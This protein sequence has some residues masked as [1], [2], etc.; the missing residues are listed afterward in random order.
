MSTVSDSVNMRLKNPSKENNRNLLSNTFENEENYIDNIIKVL[1]DNLISKKEILYLE[2]LGEF[3][4]G[5]LND[6]LFIDMKVAL[7]HLYNAVCLFTQNSEKLTGSVSKFIEDMRK[8]NLNKEQ[9]YYLVDWVIG[10]FEDM[11]YKDGTNTKKLIQILLDR[12]YIL[13]VQIPDE[14]NLRDTLKGIMKEELKR[15][16]ETLN[17]VKPEKRLRFIMHMMQYT[18][19]QIKSTSSWTDE[20]E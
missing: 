2:T 16:P 7:F 12:V 1:S 9:M 18:M 4:V 3:I 13:D 14:K 17:A 19:P 10:I 11:E 8:D 6:K 5:I 15:L 20:P